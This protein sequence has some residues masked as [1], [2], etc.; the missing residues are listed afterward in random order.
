MIRGVILSLMVSAYSLLPL[1]GNAAVEDPFPYLTNIWFVDRSYGWMLG[2]RDGGGSV[3][4]QT[5]DGGRNWSEQYQ[6]S[7]GLSS[8]RFANQQIGW[9]V[10]NSG[11]VLHTSNGGLTWEDQSS[12][13]NALLTGLAI[14]DPR[15]AW[16][17]GAHST[18][19]STTDGG[20]S[21]QRKALLGADLHISDVVFA[22]KQFGWAIGYGTIFATSDGGKSWSLSSSGEWKQLSSVRFVNH[23]DGW[24]AVGPVLLKSTDGGKTLRE[25]VPPSQGNIGAICFID[26]SN[27]W[28]VKGRA[29]Q[30]DAAHIRGLEKLSSETFILATNDGGLTWREVLHLH[31]DKDSSATVHSIFFIDK[32]NGWAVGKNDLILRTEDGG[33]HWAKIDL[34]VP[35]RSRNSSQKRETASQAIDYSGARYHSSAQGDLPR[36]IRWVLASRGRLTPNSSIATS[37]LET[38]R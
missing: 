38:I 12:G 37:T 10:G 6:T 7:E 26:A 30:G 16:V 25:I 21:W 27:G 32:L 13:T 31:S 18:L 8:V 19:L 2:F 14:L 24:I 36:P 23:S 28:L 9:A 17:S 34:S 3:I 1:H 22:D 20:K 15:T 33:K 11:T 35:K 4:Y 5:T 29:E